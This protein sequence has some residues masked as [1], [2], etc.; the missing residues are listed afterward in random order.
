[1]KIKAFRNLPYVRE[2]TKYAHPQDVG[3]DLVACRKGVI[4][5]NSQLKVPTGIG[6]E[7]PASCMGLILPRSSLAEQFGISILGGVIDEGYR[8]EI[9]VHLNNNGPQSLSIAEGDRVAQLVIMPY[10]RATLEWVD[11]LTPTT[12]GDRSHGSTGGVPDNK[13]TEHA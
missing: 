3:I 11:N 1:M 5:I 9:W 7:F 12:R 6:V 8:G 13:G 4:A 10:H 2:H